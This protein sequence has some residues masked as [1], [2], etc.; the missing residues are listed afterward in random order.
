MIIRVVD[1]ETTDLPPEGRVCEIG[2]CD[3][4]ATGIGTPHSVLVNPG[5]PVSPVAR[6]A[7]HIKDSQLA[8]AM[9]PRHGFA[10]LD[11]DCD[12][13][14]A[15]NAKFER[16]F[17]EG[18]KGKWICTYRCAMHT[19]PDAPKYSNQALR[20]W[21][22]LDVDE[23]LAMPL[24]RAGPDAYVTAH[25]LRVLMEV[26][27]VAELVRLTESPVLLKT[28]GFG[29]HFGIKWIDVPTDYCEWCLRH[30]DMDPDVLFTAAYYLRYGKKGW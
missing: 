1:F 21:L 20:Y 12:V 27:S 24:H 18:G 17:Y 9:E 16:A 19:W 26:R 22:D 11:E 14:A 29:K 2:W 30:K 7:H 25:I 28:V 15:H 6:A 3:V 8:D 10:L 4:T 23:A 5:V 13:F